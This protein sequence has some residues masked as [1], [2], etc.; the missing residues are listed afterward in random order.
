MLTLL[1]VSI[2]PP[3]VTEASLEASLRPPTQRSTERLEERL[4]LT[5]EAQR[6]STKEGGPPLW[7]EGGETDAA[8][9]ALDL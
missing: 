3:D 2:K 1:Q 8:S 5:P 9:V 7:S 4:P 6:S